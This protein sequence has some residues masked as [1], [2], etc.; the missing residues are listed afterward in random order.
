MSRVLHRAKALSIDQCEICNHT[1]HLRVDNFV[2]SCECRFRYQEY[3]KYSEVGIPDIYWTKHWTDYIAP[4]RETIESVRKY[5]DRLDELYVKSV[6]LYLY[7]GFGVGKTGLLVEV[8]K[9]AIKKYSVSFLFFPDLIHTLSAFDSV[10]GEERA[11]VEDLLT[12]S[13]FLLL[14]DIGR[15]YR[16][17]GS[18]WVGANIDQYFRKRVNNGL[19][20]LMTSNFSL[21]KAREFYGESILSVFRG[22]L[23]PIKVEGRDFREIEGDMKRGLLNA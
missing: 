19:P 10:S 14:D 22:S 7:G 23:I 12:T 5:I 11:R 16:K 18:S 8:L 21:D 6:G 13:D 15:E 3:Q 9:Q 4:D 1:G 17:E 20:T 2:T